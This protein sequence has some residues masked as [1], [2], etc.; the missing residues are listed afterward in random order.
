MARRSTC[1]DWCLSN[2]LK[3][4][5]MAVSNIVLWALLR[6]R[7]LYTSQAVVLEQATENRLY[8]ALTQ[9]AHAPT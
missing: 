9:P 1:L 2:F 5:V 6:P 8:R 4:K 3:L 7:V